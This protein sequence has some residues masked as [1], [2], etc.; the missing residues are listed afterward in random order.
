MRF[1]SLEPSTRPDK[2]YMIKFDEP[3]KVIHFGSKNS[4]TYLD[5]KDKKKRLNYLRRHS[6]NE[7][8]DNPLTAGALSAYLLWGFSTY[9]HKNLEYFLRYFNIHPS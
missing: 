4:R 7:N 8:W 3:K 1:V 6:V 2:K 9:L 5:H